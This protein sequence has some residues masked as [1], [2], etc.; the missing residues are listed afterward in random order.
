MG[1]IEN[2]AAKVH[3]LKHGNGQI[4]LLVALLAGNGRSIALKVVSRDFGL[5]MIT[6][7][8]VHEQRLDRRRSLVTARGKQ[9]F[10]KAE[11]IVD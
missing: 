6:Q 10:V 2:G 1:I 11:S 3:G 8:L 4:V 7:E 9:V 5:P